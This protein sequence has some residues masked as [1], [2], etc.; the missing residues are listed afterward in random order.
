[1]WGKV[2]VFNWAVREDL[3]KKVTFGQGVK[4][5]WGHLPPGSLGK[6]MPGIGNSKCKGPEV[7][8]SSE[9]ALRVEGHKQGVSG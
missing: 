6:S 5:R 4:W 2:A 8:R 1:M 9:V 3:T 7:P